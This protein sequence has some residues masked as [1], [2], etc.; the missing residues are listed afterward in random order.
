MKVDV[1]HGDE[2]TEVEL[3][4]KS[5]V[6]DALKGLDINSETVIVEK[7]GNMVS[8]KEELEAGDEIKLIDIVS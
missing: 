2:K 6:E 4:G 8:R 3:D 7:D 5:T 1:E